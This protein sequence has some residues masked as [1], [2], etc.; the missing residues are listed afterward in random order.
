MG[1]EVTAMQLGFFDPKPKVV[2]P[3]PDVSSNLRPYQAKAVTRIREALKENRSTLV[4][5]PT[6]TGKTQI[7]TEVIRTWPG[8]VLLIAHR[9]ELLSQA[10]HRIAEATR[11]LVGLEQ[12]GWYAGDERIV[13]A[14]IQSIS[15]PDRLARWAPDTFGLVV[16]DEAHHMPS[17]TY[18]R[19]QEH[20]ASAKFLGVT[21]TPDRHDEKAMGRCFDTVADVYEI[22][23]A[24]HDG[25]LCQIRVRQVHIESIDLRAVRTVAGDFNQGDLDKA[26]AVEEALHGVATA[27]LREAGSRKTL[28]FTTSVDNTKRLSEIMNRYR[29]GCARQVDGETPMNL[30]RATLEAFESG[31]FQFLVNCGIATEGYDCPKISCIAMARP[32]K[33]RALFAQMVG[34]GLRIHPEKSDGCMVLEF[35]GNSGK[36][37]LASTVD[38]L[39]GRYTDS[40]VERAK[41]IVRESP[42]IPADEALRRAHE[43]A[44]KKAQAEMA[45][46]AAVKAN[47]R[48]SVTDIDP[49]SVL[50][51]RTNRDVEWGVRFGGSPPTEK[52]MNALEKF[53]VDIPKNCTKQQASALLNACFAR[54]N[55]GLARYK[56]IKLLERHGI[57]A[58]N[59]KMETASVLID[60][61]KGNGWRTPPRNVLDSLLARQREREPGEEG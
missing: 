36:H 29:E 54:A 37:S 59:I 41:N 8:R 44:E 9:D 55:R 52:Q 21:A 11:E 18:V 34:R 49:F 7:F 28:M 2:T 13:V 33:S 1:Y 3:P 5:A 48:Y 35:T 42:G 19:T 61:L 53:G 58:L 6:G 10:R 15:Q 45:R 12:A 43:E 30:R 40:E 56:Q 24:I 27:T 46:R 17:P 25:W 26:M 39:G 32:T 4:V 22:E 38:I 31:Q 60:A 23:D 20:F 51:L 14:S 47:V 16:C 50:H 57:P